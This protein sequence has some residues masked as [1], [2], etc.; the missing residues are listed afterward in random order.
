M[1]DQDTI[2]G[3]K[4]DSSTSNEGTLPSGDSSDQ[5][6]TI[7]NERGEQKYA[8]V[9]K[10]LEALAVSQ[11]YIPELHNK[12]DA[13]DATIADLRE[14]LT[15]H[16][17]VDDVLQ[18]IQTTRQEP[19][20]TQPAGLGAGDATALF[21]Q[22]MET[23][24]TKVAR[25]KNI[26]AV[27]AVMSESYGEKAEEVFYAKGKELGLTPDALNDLAG[28]SPA[29]VLELF[30]KKSS[31]TV[32]VTQTSHTGEA[33]PQEKEQLGRNA[34]KSVLSGST[35]RDVRA[36]YETVKGFVKDLHDA[37]VTVEELSD[38]KLFRKH[39]G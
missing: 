4:P 8:D 34:G 12:M 7:T 22:L 17:A 36:E 20:P 39:F 13:K 25:G 3:N 24:D 11:T 2:F 16:E 18:R 5:L 33:N 28:T 14:Q 19:E 9:S 23:R 32:N 6:K 37:G 27:T 38:P 26:S 10:A 29:A 21:E 1:S 30:G 15:K 35:S 31:D